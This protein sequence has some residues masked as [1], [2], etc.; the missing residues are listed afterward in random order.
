MVFIQTDCHVMSKKKH[1]C[2]AKV[3]AWNK[4]KWNQIKF[5]FPFP[6]MHLA[7]AFIQSDLQCIQ[8]IHCQSVTAKINSRWTLQAEVTTSN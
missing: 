5:P 1:G 7:D 6:F 8:S 4:V 2:I 3:Q